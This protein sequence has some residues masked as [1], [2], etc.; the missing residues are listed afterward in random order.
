MAELN[1]GQGICPNCHK[2]GKMVY[3]PGGI[4][5]CPFCNYSPVLDRVMHGTKAVDQPSIDPTAV[6]H[7][8]RT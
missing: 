5:Y 7:P 8:P 6:P 3:T 2:Y 4:Q 1:G